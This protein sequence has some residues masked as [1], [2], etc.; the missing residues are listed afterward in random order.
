MVE[1][2]V[3]GAGEGNLASPA[4]PHIGKSCVRV[5]IVRE[6][7]ACLSHSQVGLSMLD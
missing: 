1:K 7:K 6:N 2:L 4:L 5:L 3:G